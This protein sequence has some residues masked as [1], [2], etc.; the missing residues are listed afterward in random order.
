MSEQELMQKAIAMLD[1]AYVPYSHFPVGAALECEDGYVAAGCNIENS[2][3]GLTIC[4]ERTAAVKAVSEG[5]TKFNLIFIAGRSD[6]YCY[7]CGACRQVLYEFGPDM[8]V[9]CLNR[10][11]EAKKMALRELLPCGFDK[12]WL[13]N[14]VKWK[15]RRTPSFFFFLL[16]RENAECGLCRDWARLYAPA[17]KQGEANLASPCAV[18]AFQ[19]SALPTVLGCSST[20]RMLETPVRYITMRSKPRPKPA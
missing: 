1:M 18:F 4:A 13:E 5:H 8:E 9:I 6:D 14:G 10:N 20:S 3:Y 7:P 17:K 12:T 16:W 15:R 11:G 2:S 19:K